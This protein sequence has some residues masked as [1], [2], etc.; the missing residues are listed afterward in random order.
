MGVMIDYE[1]RF[2]QVSADETRLVWCVRTRGRAGMRARL[3]A[4]I[5]S[6]LIDRAWPRF[7]ASMSPASPADT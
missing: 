2:E 6:R 7:Q 4:T 5:Y 3:F 1:H